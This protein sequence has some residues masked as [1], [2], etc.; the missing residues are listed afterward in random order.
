VRQHIRKVTCYDVFAFIIIFLAALFKSLTQRSIIFNI[1][2]GITMLL[3]VFIGIP[4]YNKSTLSS[5]RSYFIARY[6]YNAFV[7]CPVYIALHVL[8]Q[9]FL[10][11]YFLTGG[12]LL[13]FELVI[14]FV[15]IRYLYKKQSYEIFEDVPGLKLTHTA[16]ESEGKLKTTNYTIKLNA[17]AAAAYLRSE[18]GEARADEIVED[19]Q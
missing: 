1:T 15:Y 10:Q 17:Q 14:A 5:M 7:V 19:M 3:K 8:T 2:I 9:T 6:A 16:T 18:V 11:N 13:V 12:L 4:F